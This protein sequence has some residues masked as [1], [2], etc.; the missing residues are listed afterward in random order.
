VTLAEVTLREVSKTFRGSVVVDRLNLDIE[1]GEFLVLVGPSGC[2]KS[3][4]L[5]MV[6][7]LEEPTS[8][9]IFIGGRNVTRLPPKARGVA[10]V[11]QNYALYPHLTV[12]GNL[13]FGLAMARVPPAE[14][15]RKVTGI[16]ETLGIVDL[17]ERRP[18]ELSGGQR[19]RVALGRAIVRDPAVF[20]FDEPLSNL[21]A[22][23][24]V[25]MRFEI[26]QLHER[27]AATAIYVT[28]DQVEAMTLGSRVV[29]MDRG[30][31]QQVGTPIGIYERPINRFVAQ[32]MGSPGMNFIECR[33]QR[34]GSSLRLLAEQLQLDV[35]ECRR[36]ALEACN[37]SEVVIGIRPEH[38]AVLGNDSGATGG[39]SARVEG[40]E[41]LGSQTYLNLAIGPHRLVASVPPTTALRPHQPVT[42]SLNG[43]RVHVFHRG[44]HGRAVV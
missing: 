12:A 16:A 34:E 13:G 9:Q 17:L 10:M 43:E 22:Q 32:F 31:V 11:F 4:T 21:D 27:L 37:V 39:L 18:R 36:D 28:H 20:L 42:V 7:G 23:L 8:G 19:Q 29:V 15:R 38:V 30:V 24:R 35:P 5:N 26:K 41:A 14:I 33:L 6:A 44:T 40:M 25:Q 1:N 2:G 3:T